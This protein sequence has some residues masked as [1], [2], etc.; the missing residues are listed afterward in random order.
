MENQPNLRTKLIFWLLLGFLSVA[1]AEV[2]VASAPLAFINPVETVFLT[3]FYGAH[4][5]AFAWLAF[6]KGWPSLYALWFAGVLF[7]LYEFYITK[8]L[9]APPW[10]DTIILANVDVIAFIVLAL[11]W[12]PFMAFIFPLTI[13]ER[14]GTTSRWVNG[15]LPAWLVGLTA[16][17]VAIALG[18]V[19]YS[20]GA[21]TGNPALAI[22]AALSALAAV[23]LARRWWRR[24]GRHRRWD[25]A[26]LLPT[27]RQAR[28]VALILAV[29]Y[30]AFIPLWRPDSM[31]SLS[32][33]TAVWILYAT[34]AWLLYRSLRSSDSDGQPLAVPEARWPRLRVIRWT[35]ALLTLSALGSLGPPEFGAVIIWVGAIVT[36]LAMLVATLR[37]ELRGSARERQRDDHDAGRAHTS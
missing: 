13:A 4:L 9:W 7:G 22:A 19:A 34:F 12:H 8:V 24:G 28:G 18:I 36:G 27:D 37:H 21:L 35:G 32:G 23:L 10:G 11:F 26:D 6:R 20:H 5:L 3:A 31:P 30:V 2:T 15:R 25:L 16:R 1:I 17:R 33:Q 14:W 29:F